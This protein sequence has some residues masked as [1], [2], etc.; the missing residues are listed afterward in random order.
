MS[1]SGIIDGI[2][3]EAESE[4]ESTLRSARRVAEREMESARRKAETWQ[5]NI[6][7]RL[8][9]DMERRFRS[10]RADAVGEANSI[11]LK[12][13]TELLDRAFQMALERTSQ[14]PRDERYLTLLERYAAE[15]AA[16]LEIDTGLIRCSPR[17]REF[18]EEGNRLEALTSYVREQTGRHVELQL[19]DESIPAAGG[20]AA[21]ERCG[22]TEAAPVINSLSAVRTSV[23]RTI[24][25]SPPGSQG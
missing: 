12:K 2:A 15:G 1:E 10:A 11:L 14:M 18:L 8:R 20:T 13:R 7:A 21:R 22:P 24:D 9:A 23:G 25:S 16:A 5:Q 17:D 4:A 6:T 3:K 19:S